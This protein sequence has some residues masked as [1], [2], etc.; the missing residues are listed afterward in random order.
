[1]SSRQGRMRPSMLG[2]MATKGP[3]PGQAGIFEYRN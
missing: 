2:T 1:M 3:V